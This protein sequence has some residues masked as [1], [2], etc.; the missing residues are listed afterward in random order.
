MKQFYLV[1]LLSVLSVFGAN[2]AVGDKYEGELFDS[3]TVDVRKEAI[4][5]GYIDSGDWIMYKSVSF[6]GTELGVDIMT[7]GKYDGVIEF[8]IDS[9]KGAV[10]GT[11]SL[12]KNGSWTNYH[13]VKGLLSNTTGTHPLYLSF[14]SGG[15]NLDYFQFTAGVVSYKIS[16]SVKNSEGGSVIQSSS[17]QTV[18]ENTIVTFGAQRNSGYRFVQWENPEGGVISTLNPIGVTVTSDTSLVAVFE[19]I[20]EVAQL[21]EW[22]FDKQYVDAGNDV[23][24]PNIMPVKTF[25]DITGKVLNPDNY[26]TSSGA[27]MTLNAESGKLVTTGSSQTF[28][29]LWTDPNIVSDF[30]DASQH[31]QYCQFAF[32]TTGFQDLSVEYNFSGGQSDTLDYVEMVYS[33]DA[34]VTWVDAKRSMSAAHWNTWVTDSASLENAVNLP[35]VQVR[36]IGNTTHTGSNL[37]FNLNYFRVKGRVYDISTSKVENNVS[38]SISVVEGKVQVETDKLALVTIYSVLGNAIIEKMVNGTVL[39]S[40]QPGIYIVKAGKDIKKVNVLKD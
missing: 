14:T 39:F 19:A 1:A 22:S 27:S 11:V 21:P 20:T 30:T 33:V 8:R 3:T 32:P 7:S 38:N 36:L 6:D 16:S 17:T 18:A 28:R 5:A 40:L 10:I 2:A 13:V 26:L 12:P 34:G 31:K 9:L 23:L 37:N 29:V 35:S 4:N 15:F 24:T 25:P